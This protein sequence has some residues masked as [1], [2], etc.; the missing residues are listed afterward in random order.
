MST[1]A[2][3]KE[4]IRDA[5]E[6]AVY[7]LHSNLLFPPTDTVER[8]VSDFDTE[9]FQVR[10]NDDSVSNSSSVSNQGVGLL[11]MLQ[12][13]AKLVQV[14]TW[15][16][17]EDL[18][19]GNNLMFQVASTELVVHRALMDSSDANEYENREMLLNQESLLD[20]DLWTN[21]FEV[22]D[23]TDGGR[24]EITSA[25]TRS[26]PVVTYTISFQARVTPE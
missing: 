19:S 15:M 1:L 12:P 2:E 14:R 18:S 17:E 5:A 3:H 4:A 13:G 9:R 10:H 26:G 7:G 8:T 22:Q 16:F 21:L 20:G 24:P 23:F 6:V 11:F 25:P